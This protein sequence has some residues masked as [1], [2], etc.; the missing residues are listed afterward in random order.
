MTDSFPGEF[1]DMF[2]GVQ[3]GTT[4]RK[5]DQVE[6]RVSLDK[7]AHQ[8]FVPRGAIQQE[9]DRATWKTTEHMLEKVNSVVAIQPRQG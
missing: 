3:V 7:A 9:Q 4:G 2:L 8:S 6:P 5:E 1:P